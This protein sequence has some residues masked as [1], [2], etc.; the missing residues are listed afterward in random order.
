MGGGKGGQC[1]VTG[2]R[3]YA[4][5][6]L[7][8]CSG[9]DKL[10]RI[11]VG[12]KI[13]YD[14][15]ATANNAEKYTVHGWT[16]PHVVTANES[17]IIN[18]IDLFGGE[19]KEGGIQ[20]QVDA[21]FGLPTQPRNSYLQSILGNNIP[22][23][24]GLFSLIIKHCMLSANNP[25]IKQWWILGQRTEVGW[26]SDLSKITAA[27][28]F[29]DMNAVHIIY[30]TLVNTTWGG[31]GYPI[32]DLDI[33][34][35]VN[36]ATTLGPDIEKFGLSL[37]W[38]KN[39]SAGA[40]IDIVLKTINAVQ[41]FSHYTG[42]L[43]IKLIRNDY[44]IGIIPTLDESNIL[45]LSEFSVSSSTECVNQITVNYVDR[46][47]TGQSCTIQDLAGVERMDGQI[48]AMTVD[49]VG[50]TDSALASRVAARE[51]TQASIPA[52][53]CTIV[54]NRT[55]SNLNPG[56]C[57]NFNW[58]SLGI[59]GMVMRISSVEIG[60]HKTNQIIIKAVRDV[61]SYGNVNFSSP[62]SSLWTNPISSPAN[63][64]F[65]R[66]EELTWWQFVKDYMG[67]S[68]PVLDELTDTSTL[69]SCF[70]GKASRDSINYQMW[71]RNAGSADWI[72]RDT[73]SFPF[74]V[75]LSSNV[76][77]EVQ[78][79]LHIVE[80]DIDTNL[81]TVG[82][83][84]FLES[85]IVSVVSFDTT[86]KTIT[87]N[88][89]VLDTVSTAHT[90]GANIWFSQS[91]YGLDKTE[92]AVTEVV[93]VKILPSTSTGRLPIAS[94]SINTRTCTGRM[95]RPYPP[96]NVKINALRWP[97]S[98]GASDPFAI[99]WAH[100][101]RV[102]QTVTLNKQ[103]EADIGPESNVTY[104]LRIY[105]ETNVLKKTV[106]GI[107][108]TSYTWTTEIADSGLGRLNTSVRFELESVRGT[109]TSYQKWNITVPR[110]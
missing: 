12:D 76:L 55:F 89:G 22:A 94:A 64:L 51:L 17:L 8:F 63:A 41:Y 7:V 74:I 98:I 20:G 1:V 100:R 82:S 106:S 43:T 46:D 73:D 59:T 90:L 108:T 99:T 26:R 47:N 32:S 2:Y 21:Q 86:A 38:A 95:M 66:V 40:F 109:L 61:F 31:L 92:R 3:Y 62:I 80:G 52:V 67:D 54:I 34:S 45:E 105:G 68:Q 97:V 48:N 58:N 87:V 69:I 83:Y 44:S 27:D 70:C 77:P 102:L 25:Y 23:F 56:D 71:S 4:G 57:F 93:E 53:A 107:N 104:T 24:R 10:L 9:L 16:A 91:L 49:Y 110:V 88:R 101:S 65:I 5:V 19:G 35:Y 75:T 103:D 72:L 14:P 18:E 15:T 11:G 78:S 30:E 60:D 85:E 33:Q 6:H 36:A 84:A 81:V 50:I 79:V 96:G 37:V 39:T 42:L 13:A 28:G 29:I